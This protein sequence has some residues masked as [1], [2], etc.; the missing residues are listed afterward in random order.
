M[1]TRR[2]ARP[3]VLL[4]VVEALLFVASLPGLGIETRK[5]TQYAMW[6][7]P[8]FLG[9]TIVI[10]AGAVVAVV[11]ARRPS[12]TTARVSVIVG[13]AAIAITLFDLSAIAGPPDPPGPLGLS[14]VVLIVSGAML[15]L[16]Y[17]EIRS[18][19]LPPS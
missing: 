8:I 11:T 13:F 1:G 10:F 14:V 3:L 6:A 12:L 19:R 7:A 15:L 18:S 16:A 17:R 5:F 4:L 9:L 2:F